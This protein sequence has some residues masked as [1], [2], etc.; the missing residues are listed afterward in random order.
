MSLD[1]LR[2]ICCIMVI[3]IHVT[4]DYSFTVISSQPIYIQYQSL[5]IQSIVRIGLPVFFML[6]GYY[7]L[8]RKTDNLLKFYTKRISSIALPFIIYSLM[9]FYVMN[10][11]NGNRQSVFIYLYMIFSG[12]TTLSVHFWFVYA[13]LGLYI[14]SPAIK[15]ITDKIPEQ[16]TVK[17]II[18]MVAI[19]YYSLYSYSASQSFN[20]YHHL[21][22]VQ[23]LD[24]WL[25]YFIV[26][27]L[28]KRITISKK[29]LYT[30][31]PLAL[32]FHML[33]VCLSVNKF[34]FN[35]YPYDSGA[36]MLLICSILLMVFSQIN[37]VTG[38]VMSLIIEKIAPLTYGIYLVHVFVFRALEKIFEIPFI[39]DW[40]ALKTLSLSFA[41]F[42]I[43]AAIVVA[44]DTFLI[45]PVL[46]KI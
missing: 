11:I 40:I 2:I 33:M 13:M 7:I 20:S 3:A 17:S 41:I 14:I 5:V 31:L 38:S 27:G 23:G 39:V 26:G 37:L 19:F 1:L 15:Y 34:N 36:N 16:D 9:H 4:P 30:S 35:I 21:I 22:P 46:S 18:I 25:L 43:S 42:I 45:K 28:L 44:I 8:N 24:T 29:I 32:V 12:S 10:Y 6:S